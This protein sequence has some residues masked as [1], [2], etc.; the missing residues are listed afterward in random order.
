MTVHLLVQVIP[1]ALNRIHK[2]SHFHTVDYRVE[3]F[4]V[5]AT[6]VVGKDGVSTGFERC[7]AR[8]TG[9]CMYQTLRTH[10]PAETR[11]YPVC[12]WQEHGFLWRACK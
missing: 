5:Q 1:L 12:G 10:N 9:D 6:V 4:E 8:Y 2:H 11:V 3:K 7:Q